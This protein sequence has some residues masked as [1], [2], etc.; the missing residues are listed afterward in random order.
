MAKKKESISVEEE[1]E[2]EEGGE[3]EEEKKMSTGKRLAKRSIVGSK[4][5]VQGDD[6]L[7]YPAVIQ[8]VRTG[9]LGTRY[10]VRRYGVSG[11]AG[12]GTLEYG[13]SDLI[14]PGFQ[15][16]SALVLKA[17]QRVYVT[18]TGREI[19]GQVTCHR[20]DVDQVHITLLAPNSVI[21]YIFFLFF[22]SSIII[23]DLLDLIGGLVDSLC[24]CVYVLH[25]LMD[26]LP[27]QKRGEINLWSSL[28]DKLPSKENL[29]NYFLAFSFLSAW[30]YEEGGRRREEG[31]R[32]R[33]GESF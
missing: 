9:D 22:F 3:E 25:L 19:A 28:E 6:G 10:A 23:I 1:E 32:R 30:R 24:V 8:A 31:G 12:S 16:S 15:S 11:S 18:F 26:S 21:I 2:E 29:A 20:P 5:V 13:E 14:G 17:G 4:V 33:R 27:V 7:Y